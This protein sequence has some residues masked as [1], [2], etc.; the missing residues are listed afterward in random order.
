MAHFDPIRGTG[1][2]GLILV[3]ASVGCMLG[4]A[5]YL[6]RRIAPT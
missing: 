2:I 1:N 6:F 5:A 3:L 4:A